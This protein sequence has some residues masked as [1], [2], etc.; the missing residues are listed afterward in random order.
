MKRTLTWIEAA[1]TCAM[2][3]VVLAHVNDLSYFRLGCKAWWSVGISVL[4]CFTVPMF[5][6]ISGYLLG[7]SE[8]PTSHSLPISLFLKRKFETLIIPFLAWNVIYMVLFTLVFH[9]PLLSGKT[10]WYLATG[11]MHLYFVFVLIQFFF[12]FYLI[13]PY[14][15][16]QGL[17]RSLIGAVIFTALFY[18]AS[19]LLLWTQGADNHFFEWHYGKAFL[20]WSL[21]FFWGVW[22]GRSPQFLAAMS[23]R[24]LPLGLAAAAAFL[25]FYWETHTELD[26]FG[27]NARQYFLITGVLYQFIG[28]SFILALLYRLDQPDRRSFSLNL[29]AHSGVD[30]YGIYLSH[31]AILI[32][33]LKAWEALDL[34]VMALIKIPVLLVATWF[35]SQFLVRVSQWSGFVYLSK[36]LF[37]GRGRP[38]RHP[39]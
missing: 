8:N 5:F 12:L 27:Y 19:D 32:G 25:A 9:W 11:Y 39:P 7:R 13:K 20:G 22:L 31:L 18:I 38:V 24:L 36:I 16:G 4:V 17:M 14:L 21:F 2:A 33:L 35:L 29:L 34:P 15:H 6:M 28:A 1:R 3:V 30:T 26:L 37:G 23:K 10:I